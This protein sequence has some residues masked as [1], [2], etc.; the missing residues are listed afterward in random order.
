MSKSIHLEV[1]IDGQQLDVLDETGVIRS[2][3][4]STG[5]KGVGFREGSLRTPVG[6]FRVSEKIGGDQQR[7]TIFKK[8]EPVGIWEQGTAEDQDLVLTRILRL[9]GLDP[10]NANTLDRFIYIHG[11]NQE[12]LIGQPA[13]EGCVRLA[14]VEMEELFDMVPVGASLS[15][16]PPQQGRGNIMFFDCDSTLSSIEGIDELARARG[17][18]VYAQ[19]VALTDAAMN[20]EIPL[21]EVFPRRMEIIRPDRQTCEEV[22]AKY[23]TTMMPGAPELIAWLKE[24]GWLPIIV[25]GGFA[26]LIKPLADLLGIEHVEAVPLYLDADGNYAGYGTDYPTTRNLGKNEIIREWKD[27]LLPGKTAMMGDG[28][29]DLETKSDVDWFIGFGGVVARPLVKAGAEYWVENLSDRNIIGWLSNPPARD[30]ARSG[31]I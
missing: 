25:S 26:P 18:E 12:A 29:S 6:R 15:I 13:S 14:N 31:E 17:P 4:I 22:A 24:N 28:I 11:T 19:V 8:R 3:P 1:S 16:L 2:F 10:E 5:K 9:E 30:S 27:A 23:I 20:G 21:D 7:H